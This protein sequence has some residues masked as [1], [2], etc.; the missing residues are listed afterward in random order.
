MLF[1]R[2]MVGCLLNVGLVSVCLLLPAKLLATEAS[3]LWEEG[4]AFLGLYSVGIFLGCLYLCV[5]YPKS[6]EARLIVTS[7]SQPAQDKMATAVL[8]LAGLAALSFIPTDVFY[9]HALTA[10]TLLARLVG[11]GLAQ[12]GLI[13]MFVTMVQNEF[14]QPVVSIQEDRGHVL[15]DTGLYGRV[16]HPLYTSFLIWFCGAA[17]WLGSVMMASFGTGILMLALW[18]RILIEESTLKRD[19]DGYSDYMRRVKRRIIPGLL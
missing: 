16:R 2:T 7:P 15:V 19:L 9:L 14:A 10:P 4:M 11:L 13:L 17:L 5:Y 8:S 1:K 6:M 18:P 3:W 12:V